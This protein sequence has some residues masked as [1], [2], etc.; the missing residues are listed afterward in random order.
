MGYKKKG[1]EESK[2][3]HNYETKDKS[4]GIFNVV[5]VDSSA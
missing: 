4:C 3:F 5:S 2:V 1:F